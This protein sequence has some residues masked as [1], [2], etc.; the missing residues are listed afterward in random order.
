[1]KIFL[2]R[3]HPGLRQVDSEPRGRTTTGPLAGLGLEAHTLIA[4]QLTTLLFEEMTE[5]LA[6]FKLQA[7]ELVVR[8]FSTLQNRRER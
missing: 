4:D 8:M 3:T 7:E 6:A 2:K 5:G 1:M